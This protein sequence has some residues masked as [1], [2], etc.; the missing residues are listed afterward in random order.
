LLGACGSAIGPPAHAAP[1]IDYVDGAIEPILERGG[2]AVIEGFG[3]GAAQETGGVTFAGAGGGTIPAAVVGAG[4]WSDLAVRVTVPDPGR[5]RALPV[6]RAF[7]AAAVATRYNSH[8]TGSALYVIG[9][10]DSAGRPQPSV[11]AADV[12]PDGV[13]ARFAPIEPLPTPVAGATAVVRRGRIYVIGGTDSLGRP[14][15]FVFVGRVAADGHI[16]GWYGQPLL[17]RRAP[18]AAAS[19]WTTA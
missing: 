13:A 2:T 4:G 6:P 15:R 9:G 16:D 3:F 10:V 1:R 8:F 12:T 18:T 5:S 17:R 7:A 11:F 14:Q 19:S